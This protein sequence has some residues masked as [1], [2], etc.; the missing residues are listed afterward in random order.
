MLCFGIV[1][2]VKC[3]LIACYFQRDLASIHRMASY[4]AVLT[5]LKEFV[6]QAL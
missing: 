1:C 3:N 2:L 5:A 4:Q 6:A